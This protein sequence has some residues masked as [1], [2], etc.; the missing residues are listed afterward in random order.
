MPLLGLA[1]IIALP[2]AGLAQE[3]TLHAEL[4]GEA[5]RLSDTCA[6]QWRSI[7]ACGV[8]LATDT[9]LHLSI[10]SLPPQNGIGIGEAFVLRKNTN[11]WRMNWDI[12]GVATMNGSWRAGVMMTMARAA[13]EPMVIVSPSSSATRRKRPRQLTQ[14][15]T[16]YHFYLQSSS[17]QSLD[18]YGL[19]D[20]TAAS[21]ATVFGMRETIVGVSANKPITKA[22]FAQALRLSLFANANGRFVKVNAP[23]GQ[24]FAPITARFSDITAPG[25]NNQPAYFQST[26]GV[27]IAPS[28]GNLNFD[29]SLG[30][31]QFATS[32]SAHG[33]FVRWTLDLNHTY[34]LYENGPAIPE[35]PTIGPDQCAAVGSS[36]ASISHERNLSGSIGF[37]FHVVASATGTSDRIP[38]YF[39]PTLGGAD[40]NGAT[41]LGS[42]A[43]YRFRAPNLLLMR[44]RFE[45]SIWGPFGFEALADEGK[46]ALTRSAL[47]FDHLHHSFGAGMSIRAGGFPVINMLFAWGGGE[48]SHSIFGL[49]PSLLGGASRPVFD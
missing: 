39:Q 7:A 20:T 43:D 48:G 10:G 5:A 37:E 6:L 44:E 11:N 16:V 41:S 49:N 8:A 15:T 21:D 30:M 14:P 9:P 45:H 24:T 42:Y 38:F 40:I 18:F 1:A 32:S 26:E 36:C 46:V 27:R 22:S 31:D 34:G 13:N 12:D 23:A 29:Y 3:G 19:G 28:A 35:P 33:S 2:K 47:G 4:R 25:L 17:L